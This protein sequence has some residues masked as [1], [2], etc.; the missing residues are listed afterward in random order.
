MRQHKTRMIMILTVGLSIF[1]LTLGCGKPKKVIIAHPSPEY[2]HPPPAK[3]GPPP[4]APAHGHRAKHKYYYYP[5]PHVYYDTGRELY[6][7]LEGDNW[8]F[9]ASLPT[10]IHIA[11]SDHVTLE[12]DTDKPYKFHSDVIKKYPPGQMKK[13][14][15]GKGKKKHKDK[16]KGKDKKK[17][18]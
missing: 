14:K 16:G 7:Y 2:R 4:W 13:K 11:L 10:G 18:D 6:F 17:W 12:M 5:S 9:G 3:K 8:R 15:K 1:L